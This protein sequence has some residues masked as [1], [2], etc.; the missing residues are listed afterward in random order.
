MAS[1]APGTGCQQCREQC[2]AAASGRRIRAANSTRNSAG[3]LDHRE[4]AG[5]LANHADMAVEAVADPAQ[6]ASASRAFDDARG[7]RIRR[8]GLESRGRGIGGVAGPSSDHQHLGALCEPEKGSGCGPLAQLGAII[9]DFEGQQG[10]SVCNGAYSHLYI[11]IYLIGV[12][13]SFVALYCIDSNQNMNLDY[14]YCTHFEN[15]YFERA[16]L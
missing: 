7:G 1:G 11:Y 4:A 12:F 9:S 16:C 8:D 10:R 15:Q 2:E 5:A 3:L 13:S 14:D 6:P